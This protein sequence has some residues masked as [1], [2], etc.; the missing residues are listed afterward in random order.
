VTAGKVWT[1]T[2]TG[3]EWAEP[4]GGVGDVTKAYVDAQDLKIKNEVDWQFKF[5]FDGTV[6]TYRN[7]QKEWFIKKGAKTATNAQLTALVE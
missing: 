1:T 7:I 4:T 2:D 3:A 5:I 6:R